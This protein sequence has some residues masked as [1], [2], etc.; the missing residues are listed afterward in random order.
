MQ[1][2]KD[3]W[4]NIDKMIQFY[5]D[6]KSKGQIKYCETILWLLYSHQF[7]PI[8]IKIEIDDPLFIDLIA[9]VE[10]ADA[11]LVRDEILKLIKKIKLSQI[12]MIAKTIVAT[13]MK[14]I[15]EKYRM[16]Y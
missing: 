10:T 11:E 12:D 5:K 13:D 9:A 14:Y 6:Y 1:G 2:G 7:K 16:D 3:P 4:G 15:P 8:N